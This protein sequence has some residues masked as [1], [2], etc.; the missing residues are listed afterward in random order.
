[1][2]TLMTTFC[3]FFPLIVSAQ[4]NNILDLKLSAQDHYTSEAIESV[5]VILHRGDEMLS[6][7]YTGEYGEAHLQITIT[8][9]DVTEGIPSTFS[10]TE[11]YPNPFVNETNIDFS[12][13]EHQT[14]QAEVFNILGQ[15]VASE[16]LHL[17]PGHFS[18]KLSLGHLANGAYFVRLSGSAEQ[19]VVKMLKLG[20]GH[21]LPG[22]LFR[23][24]SR[25]PSVYNPPGKATDYEYRLQAMKEPYDS[26]EIYFHLESDTSLTLMME[27]NNTVVFNVLDD[28]GEPVTRW[29]LVEEEGADYER[30]VRSGQPVLLKSGVYDVRASAGV[31]DEISTE[32]E[33]PS[34][35]TTF[36]FTVGLAEPTAFIPLHGKV[37]D[38]EGEP[39]ENVVVTVTNGD[40]EITAESDEDGRVYLAGVP[41]GVDRTLEIHKDGFARQYLA[42]HLPE[43][44][45]SGWFEATL[46]PR[47]PGI[48]ISNVEE[49]G[50][51]IGIDG[52]SISLPSEG[53]VD[54][55]GNP[56]TGDIEA[57]LTSVNTDG[58]EIHSFPGSFEGVPQDGAQ[59]LILTLGVSEYVLEQGDQTL[60]LANGTKATI[61]IPLYATKHMDGTPIEEGDDFPLWLLDEETGI[62]EERSI[63]IV[64]SSDASPT[65]M[66]V[67]GEVDH[68][69]WWNCDIAPGDVPEPEPEPCLPLVDLVTLEP[70][71]CDPPDGDPVPPEEDCP[72]GT[73]PV[74]PLV[75]LETGEPV[76]GTGYCAAYPDD[77]EPGD[78]DPDEDP[79]DDIDFE[80]LIDP[81]EDV[82][83]RGTSEQNGP[84]A[85]PRTNVPAA[86]GR[87]LPMPPDQNVDLI[88]TARNGT[89]RG[90]RTYNGSP[91]DRHR[92]LIPLF[93]VATDPDGEITPGE[94][95]FAAIDPPGS[96]HSWTFDGKAGDYVDIR[97]ETAEGSDLEGYVTVF[98]P[99]G[100]SIASGSFESGKHAPGAARLPQDGTY[101]IQVRGT[102]NE[103]GAYTILLTFAD[104]IT[105]HSETSGTLE[106]GGI[107]VY[108]FIGQA[109]QHVNVALY[110]SAGTDNMEVEFYYK[111]Q[112][113]LGST[114]MTLTTA[115]YTDIGITE[116]PYSGVYLIYVYAEGTASVEYTIGLAEIQE[117]LEL[118][119]EAPS[120][121]NS[122]EITI[123]GERT[124]YSFEG[125]AGDLHN[126]VL[127]HP[128]QSD[129][130]ARI[131]IRDDTGD[132]FY[133][134][135]IHAHSYTTASASRRESDTGTFE[136][137]KDGIWYIEIDPRGVSGV[138]SNLEN[139]LGSYEVSILTPFSPTVIET[140]T[141]IEDE[142]MAYHMNLYTF[143]ADEGDLVNIPLLS[144]GLSG[145]TRYYLYDPAGE[146]IEVS[147]TVWG[148]IYRESGPM[149]F[150]SSGTY[151]LLIDG[152]EDTAGD[153]VLSISYIE[154]P[155]DI[156]PEAPVMNLSDETSIIG[157]RKYYRFE[158]NEGDL[159]NFVLSH[160]DESDMVARIRLRDDEGTEFYNGNNHL[161]VATSFPGNR[162]NDSNTFNLPSDGI[163]YIEINTARFNGQLETFRGSYEISIY[164]PLPPTAVNI[165]EE[166]E[167]ELQEYHMN[168][169]S[170]DGSESAHVNFAVLSRGLSE[171]TSFYLYD[172]SGEEIELLTVR[173][174][175]YDESSPFMLEE[176]GSYTI[177]VSG[178]G[179][180]SGEYLFSV[181]KIEEPE[182]I[183]PEI[184]FV[185]ISGETTVI[186]ERTY[187]SFEANAGDRYN[188]I[189]SHPDYSELTARMRIRDDTG[190]WFY[191]GI[192]HTHANTRSWTRE[193]DTGTFE[194]PIG[195]VWY[196]EIDPGRYN[197]GEESFYGEYDV[198]I[199][200]EELVDEMTLME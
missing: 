40:E 32:I 1:M 41:G 174:S 135:D 149:V 105:I 168:L 69:S 154:E 143:E 80:P 37:T 131:R 139:L 92:V 89:L 8:H 112:E 138:S 198:T 121:T 117:P 66:V 197:D 196:I 22:G 144:L 195:G 61:E 73:Y 93:P 64:V 178:R 4:D 16:E 182:E 157:E 155:V 9:V 60:Q 116:L 88:M 159:Y 39:L 147:Q 62:W 96:I 27:R 18:L 124:Y 126:S 12:V 167:N 2:K 163:W 172:P 99:G 97:V 31:Y 53:V 142:L 170:F 191:D 151:T 184:P 68:L 44:I 130:T 136:L 35:D 21:F 30:T 100:T 17:N 11:N 25:S 119:P 173:G 104:G 23:V 120:I 171:F 77:F 189:L 111:G 188:F 91:G 113:L 169:Y 108:A 109:G 187:Y 28:D 190:N 71:P 47:N 107:S 50:D 177:L 70:I 158:G 13:P 164:R 200:I 162:I 114:S 81:D 84:R 54:E 118:L 43:E 52:V 10:V 24:E 29:L 98:S 123:I 49:G 58:D 132:H 3:L 46:I 165:S 79:L 94:L 14:I 33:I 55:D 179:N 166:V 181:T 141:E 59:T 192:S 133:N 5:L 122:N 129:L 45:P 67:R 140:N 83:V 150:E 90:E 15:R 76:P 185:T 115:R 161:E 137:S 86:G 127:F 7:E 183:I 87:P 74:P 75:D 26:I 160:P 65:G 128:D 102:R 148:N 146:E 95:E 103:P 42:I 85:S 152:H 19:K 193:D 48:T 194:F 56:V 186:G 106:G 175:Q 125:S 63:G 101:T 134:G 156:F 57:S 78:I 153:Y 110:R 72:E 176:T 20:R 145:L 6:S 51:A 34:V 199:E 38:I 180:A 36:S 82:Y